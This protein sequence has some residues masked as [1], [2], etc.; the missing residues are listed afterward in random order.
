MYLGVIQLSGHHPQI[1]YY[2]CDDFIKFSPLHSHLRYLRSAKSSIW[3]DLSAIFMVGR[4]HYWRCIKG[5]SQQPP[6]RTINR[7]K[8]TLLSPYIATSH[9]L[10]NDRSGTITHQHHHQHHTKLENKFKLIHHD[11][12]TDLPTLQLKTKP[13][14]C[15]SMAH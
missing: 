4:D 1:H 7:F 13:L 15:I 11:D 6:H 3:A 14:T 10:N 12:L 9:H 8:L 2:S 5:R